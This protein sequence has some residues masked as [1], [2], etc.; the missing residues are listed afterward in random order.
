MHWKTALP[1]LLTTLAA[2]PRLGLLTDMDGTISPIV[3]QPDQAQITSNSRDL[4]R[5]LLPY[6]TLIAAVSGREVNDLR[7]RID[8]P[9]LIY[10]GNHGLEW[11]VDGKSQITPEALVHRPALDAALQILSQK[12]VPG[13]LIEDKGVTISAHYRQTANP[14]V[15]EITFKLI[16]EQI[17]AQHGLTLYEGRKVFELRPPINMNKGTVLLYLSTTH[18]LDAVVFIGDDT[19]DVDGLIGARQLRDSGVCFGVGIG[20]ESPNMPPAVRDHADLLASGVPDVEA[21][22]AWL[23]NARK[24]I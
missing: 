21:F 3:D 2:K 17:A 8:L 7:A 13:M 16:L 19:T 24:R 9:G 11:W 14:D 23:L 22:L 1:T 5:A 20:V 18:K 6:V 15:V 10:I 4:L 12:Q